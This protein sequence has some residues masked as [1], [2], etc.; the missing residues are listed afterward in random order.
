MLFHQPLIWLKFQKIIRE[1][2]K[3]NCKLTANLGNS[4]I[5]HLN[6]AFNGTW[7]RFNS[8]LLQLHWTIP[9]RPPLHSKLTSFSPKPCLLLCYN[10]WVRIYQV[11]SHFL[12]SSGFAWYWTEETHLIRAIIWT[13]PQAQWLEMLTVM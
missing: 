13:I 3:F 7:V 1:F 8:P 4:K 11:I 5:R 10:I 12:L 6:R 2:S 9:P